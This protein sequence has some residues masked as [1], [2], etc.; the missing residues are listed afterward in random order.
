M[1]ENGSGREHEKAVQRAID[2][3]YTT[4]VIGCGSRGREH[5]AASE[6]VEDARPVACAGRSADGR[7]AL[8]ETFGL[9]AYDDAAEMLATHTDPVPPEEWYFWRD[10][11]ARGHSFISPAAS[12]ST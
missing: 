8:A 10:P 12:S 1:S 9:T 4:A 7:E 3:G 5:P 2:P 6:R 11:P